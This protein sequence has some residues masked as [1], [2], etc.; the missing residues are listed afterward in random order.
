MDASSERDALRRRAQGDLRLFL[1]VAR[2]EGEVE[3]V[4]GADPHLEMGALYELSLEQE[5]PPVLLFEAIKGCD[6]THRVVA[7]VRSARLFQEGR[8]LDR[9]Q[10]YR[11]QRRQK[12]EPIAPRFVNSGPVLENVQRGEAVDV[13]RF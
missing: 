12:L 13:R 5:D 8:G 4:R 9:V 6:P 3:T 11:R 1:D 7:N 2:A 10:Q